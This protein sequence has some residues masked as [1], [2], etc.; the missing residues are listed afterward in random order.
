MQR[1]VALRLLQAAPVLTACCEGC[2]TVDFCSSL[3]CEQVGPA[4][5]PEGNLV[6]FTMRK[7][8]PD[9]SL[10]SCTLVVSQ[11]RVWPVMRCSPPGAGSCL[12]C[13]P[14]PAAVKCRSSKSRA[15]SL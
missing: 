11:V 3:R 9:G 4:S 6:A 2:L 10:Q 7:S 12:S 8:N 14:G 13:L 5:N 1:Q 15:S